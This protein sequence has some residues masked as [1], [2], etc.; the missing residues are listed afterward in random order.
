MQ[1]GRTPPTHD[2][3]TLDEVV[4]RYLAEREADWMAGNLSG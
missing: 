1:I 3:V 4:N 2:A